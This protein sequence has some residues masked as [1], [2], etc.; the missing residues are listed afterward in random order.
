RLAAYRRRDEVPRERLPA[1]LAA[2]SAA[3]RER[4]RE[5]YGLPPGEQV[6]YRVVDDAP[7]SALQQHRG[8]LRSRVSVNAGARPRA[9]QLALLVAHEAY[10]GHHT[11]QCVA[12]VGPAGRPERTVFL[13]NSP[14]SVVIEG[15]ADLGLATAVGPG[16]GPWSAEVLAGAGVRTDGGLAERVDDVTAPLA[17]VRQDAALMLHAHGADQAEVRAFL[18]RWLLVDDDRAGR[19]LRFLAHPLW[20]AYTTTYVEGAPL[21]RAWLGRPGRETAVQRH[22]RLLEEP[23]PP[24]ALRVAG[25]AAA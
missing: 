13:V 25:P 3:L 17:R 8:G 21:L 24:S 10:P 19:I 22:R 2:V 5:P 11:E 7:W 9:G 15:L 23:V 18:R 16:W 12:Q 6:E 4:V 14:Q 20:R 1:A